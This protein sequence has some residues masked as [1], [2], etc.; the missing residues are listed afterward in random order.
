KNW[1][2]LVAGSDGLPNYRHHADV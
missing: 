2:V 1:A